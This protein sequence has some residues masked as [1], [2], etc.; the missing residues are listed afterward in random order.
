MPLSRQDQGPNASDRRH[1]IQARSTPQRLAVDSRQSDRLESIRVP[2]DRLA[3]NRPPLSCL[4]VDRAIATLNEWHSFHEEWVTLLARDRTGL[5]PSHSEASHRRGP[6]PKPYECHG[7]F[8]RDDL[9]S[10]LIQLL[11]RS[12]H[13]ARERTHPAPPAVATHEHPFDAIP[14]QLDER[15][16]RIEAWLASIERETRPASPIH[17]HSSTSPRSPTPLAAS[18]LARAVP[19]PAAMSTPRPNNASPSDRTMRHAATKQPESMAWSILVQPS[20]TVPAIAASI[21][22]WIASPETM[23][24]T[25]IIGTK[26]QCS[27]SDGTSE[28]RKRPSRVTP[29]HRIATEKR[30]D[31]GIGDRNER[32]PIHRFEGVATAFMGC[33]G[34]S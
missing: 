3:S 24:L 1:R 5:D 34:R 19:S 12:S 11:H 28:P 15:F 8:D 14:L 10:E 27:P 30:I 18:P 9:G 4:S 20:S 32:S 23:A 2:I 13:V 16:D 33:G 7:Y 25:R 29:P 21:G 6:L 17:R 26:H 22:T 31:L